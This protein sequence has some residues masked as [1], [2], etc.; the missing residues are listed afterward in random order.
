[1]SQTTATR[2]KGQETR[3]ALLDAAISV[4]ARDGLEGFNHRSVATEAES[5]L[6]LTT[7]YFANKQDLIEQA[8]ERFVERSTPALATVWETANTTL[9]AWEAGADRNYV[10][11]TLADEAVDYIVTTDESSTEGVAFELAFLYQPRLSPPLA[12]AVQQYRT[13]IIGSAI[14]FCERCGS[15]NSTTDAALLVGLVR[16]L[17]FEQLSGA[18]TNSRNHMKS[19]VLRLL[20]V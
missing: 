5:S 18:I 19:Q 17:E 13:R 10:L 16:R 4:I 3:N 11:R 20:D 8:F 1:M 2:R 15:L 7:Y 9:D 12:T 14:E 6:A